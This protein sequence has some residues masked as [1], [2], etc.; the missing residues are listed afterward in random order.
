M[1][2]FNT[3]IERA[4]QKPAKIVLPEGEDER[5][6]EAAARAVKRG[7]ALPILLGNEAVIKDK[8]SQLDLDINQLDIINPTLA[9]NREAL[10]KELLKLRARKGM[11]QAK[12]ADLILD[13]L[14][15]AC[16]MVQQGLAHGCVAGAVY[17]TADVVR[18][19]LQLVGKSPG[20]SLVSSFFIMLT[21]MEH[22]PI[23]DIAIFADCALVIDPDAQ[24]LAEIA[25][26]TGESARQLLNLEPQIAMLSFSTAGSADDASVSKVINATKKAKEKRPE[27]RIFGEVQLD[28][29]VV[30]QI[31]QAKAPEMATAEPAN[32]LIFPNLD[33][34]NIG[35]KLCERFG[36]AEAIGPVLQGLV[37]PVNDLSRG[38][39]AQDIYN[40]IAV[41]STQA[42]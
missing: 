4:C 13:N 26:T 33:A 40:I 27:W 29:A 7:T 42:Q 23:D 1:P 2:D 3:L 15:F 14:H 10:A 18:T 12:A 34:G 32:I 41:T 25:V 16:M 20:H 28:A 5:V 8:A 21:H 30:P 22:H 38:C 11:T 6:L 24:Q 31:L 39:K 36:G 37:K 9:K 35:Y 19:A 17:P